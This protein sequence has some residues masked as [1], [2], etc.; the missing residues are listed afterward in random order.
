[1]IA[2]LNPAGDAAA[3][4]READC[5]ILIE[6]GD[7]AQ[8]ADAVGRLRDSSELRQRLGANGRQYAIAHFSRESAIDAYETALK[9][10]AARASN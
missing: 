9:K 5:G 1:M 4:V 6:P 10:A 7:G 3:I 2:G 8:L